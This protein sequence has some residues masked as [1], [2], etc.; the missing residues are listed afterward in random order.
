[1]F[2][3]KH[4]PRL[5]H[6]TSTFTRWIA[7]QMA[8]THLRCRSPDR[9]GDTRGRYERSRRRPVNVLRP[10]RAHPRAGVLGRDWR[11]ARSVVDEVRENVAHG[12]VCIGTRAAFVAVR[13]RWLVGRAV[14]WWDGCNLSRDKIWSRL[15]AR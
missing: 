10:C 2:A 7:E 9:R 12:A 3:A 8:N 13:R 15:L 11:D 6:T 5:A 14:W 4:L 1:L